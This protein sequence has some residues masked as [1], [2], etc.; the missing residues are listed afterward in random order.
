MCDLCVKPIA[1]IPTSIP[2]KPADHRFL[3][4]GRAALVIFPQ[5]AE[6]GLRRLPYCCAAKVK[7]LDFDGGLLAPFR[8]MTHFGIA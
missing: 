6:S 1:Q 3:K 5:M 8:G 4:T 7:I 2:I